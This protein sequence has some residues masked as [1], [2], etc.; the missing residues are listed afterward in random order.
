MMIG[1][2]LM[3]IIT[4]LTQAKKEILISNHFYMHQIKLDQVLTEM[5]T[6]LEVMN[7]KRI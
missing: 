5:D 1:L 3:M 7:I 2:K 6:T 4:E